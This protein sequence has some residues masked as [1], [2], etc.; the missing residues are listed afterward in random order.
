MPFQKTTF[1]ALLHPNF[2]LNFNFSSTHSTR[3][4]LLLCHIARCKIFILYLITLQIKISEKKIYHQIFM[5][6]GFNWDIKKINWKKGFC[7][8]KLY[9]DLCN[10]H[11]Y[12]HSIS[13]SN[14]NYQNF[15]VYNILYLFFY[16]IVFILC[17]FYPKII[18]LLVTKTIKTIYRD[19]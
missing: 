15:L 17:Y 12:M 18:I 16:L 10:T 19:T 9:Q 11:L 8:E 2:V 13:Y 14:L 7:H 4:L 5:T 1:K 3:P 6:I